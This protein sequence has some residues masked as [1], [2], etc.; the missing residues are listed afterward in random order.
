MSVSRRKALFAGFTH[1]CSFSHRLIYINTTCASCNAPLDNSE[2][3]LNIEDANLYCS[4][5]RNAN[6]LALSCGKC[7][8]RFPDLRQLKFHVSVWHYYVYPTFRCAVPGCTGSFAISRV[9]DHFREDHPTIKYRCAQCNSAF[10]S[11]N[12]LDYHGDR[13]MHAAYKCRYPGCASESARIGDLHRHQLKH[14]KIVPRHPCP[15]CRK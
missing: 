2:Q 1:S 10:D 13:A 3:M 6:H 7:D 12:D 9:G 11:Q 8:Q 4:R 5:N 15:H 14:K